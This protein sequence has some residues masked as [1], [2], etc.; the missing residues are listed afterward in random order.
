MGAKHINSEWKPGGQLSFTTTAKNVETLTLVPHKT[1]CGG[2]D[3]IRSMFTPSPEIASYYFDDFV[4]GPV[5]GTAAAVGFTV[6][7]N[8]TPAKIALTDAAGGVLKLSSTLGEIGG[9]VQ[10]QQVNEWVLPASGKDIWFETKVLVRD[11]DQNL[12]FVGLCER[13][14]G[15]IQTGTAQSIGFCLADGDA[16]LFFKTTRGTA[17]AVALGV[18]LSDSTP[19][20]PV[21]ARLAFYVDSNS[22]VHAYVD[23]VDVSQTTKVSWAL[24]EIPHTELTP[25]LAYQLGVASTTCYLSVDYI[26][27]MQLR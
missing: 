9:M 2:A 15:V 24:N 11:A 19:A 13:N 1:G 17:T 8:A 14:T 6:T 22:H 18:D 27:C 5:T 10:L 12:L 16:T 26:K 23:D 20:T 21:W 4:A 3:L 25:T 7:Q